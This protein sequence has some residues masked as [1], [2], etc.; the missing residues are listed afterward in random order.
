MW[1]KNPLTVFDPEADPIASAEIA[2]GLVVEGN[3]IIEHVAAGNAPTCAEYSVFDAQDL[4]L[5]PGLINTHHHF[6]QTLTRSYRAALNKP[7]FSWLTNLYPLWRHLTPEMIDI[8]TRLASAE[9][10]LSGCTTVGDHHYI[11]SDQLAHALD[12]QANACAELGVRAVLTRGSMS[13]GQSK[14]G[15]PP[16]TIVQTDDE[17]LQ[18]SERVI[19]QWHGREADTMLQIA[20]APCSPFSVTPE[21]M[22]ETATLSARHDVLLHTHLAETEDEN[23][24]CLAQFGAR[25]LDHI[26]QCGWLHKRAWFAHGI[27]FN[28][29]EVRRLGQAGVGV[30]HCPSSNMLLSSGIC[31]VK[32]LQQAGVNVGLGV[33][34]SA[35]NDHSN[36]IE[37][38]RQALL[39]Q[40]LGQHLEQEPNAAS[41]D[42][43]LFTHTN[44]LDLATKG[45]ADLLQRSSLGRLAVGSVADL[46]LFQLDEPRFS[47]VDE[48]LAGLV[49]SGASRVS[50]LMIDGEWKIRDRMLLDCDLQ[51]LQAA[52]H[53]QALQLI[54]A[55]H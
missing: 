43:A 29:D 27:H 33:D 21:L 51:A 50:H 3:K 24:F 47:G 46:A 14:G 37:E 11:Y 9:L 35:S 2:G 52:H 8:S 36:L 13:L 28:D 26:E 48:P 44:A 1:I 6:Y 32:D 10:M 40:R 19:G 30:T 31:R 15:L 42:A 5:M 55:L 18:D 16:D 12:I 25:P 45:S 39:I 20:L 53:Q 38:V 41:S 23:T 7:L 17:I 22:Q 49:L 54:S 34:G 4:I